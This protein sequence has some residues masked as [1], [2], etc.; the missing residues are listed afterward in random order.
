MYVPVQWRRLAAIGAKK[1]LSIV[2]ARLCEKARMLDFFASLRQFDFFNCETETSK[3][4]RC[5][6][7]LSRL[8]QK[9]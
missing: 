5:E 4:F 2:N 1:G 3:C 7:K 6:L 8:K 9:T